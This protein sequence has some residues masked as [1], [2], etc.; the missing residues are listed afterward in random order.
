MKK[1]HYLIIE[2]KEDGDE[3]YVKLWNKFHKKHRRFAKRVYRN[4][5][6]HCSS[7]AQYV[8]VKVREKEE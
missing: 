2:F 4:L 3:I 8:F 6:K 5:K 1:Y 7:V